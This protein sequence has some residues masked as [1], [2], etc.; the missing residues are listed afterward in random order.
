MHRRIFLAA[1]G[2][3]PALTGCGYA[4]K[5]M[6]EGPPRPAAEVAQVWSAMPVL[7]GP[8]IKVRSEGGARGRIDIV[9]VDGHRA[10]SVGSGNDTA[11]L[12]YVLPGTR[13]FKVSY[14]L[15]FE[16]KGSTVTTLFG[17]GEVEAV[18]K[19]GQ[20]Y[21]IDAAVDIAGRAVRFYLRPMNSAETG[22][23]GSL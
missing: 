12:V 9:E 21:V 7:T 3:M 20:S 22:S 23:L 15:L 4:P 14:G 6:F 11:D 16:V 10:G 17:S 2:L 5:Q 18:L 8:E 19:A 1:I 13:R